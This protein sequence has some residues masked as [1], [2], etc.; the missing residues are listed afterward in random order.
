MS[1]IESIKK[2]CY[3]IILA[4][5]FFKKKI[6]TCILICFNSN[7]FEFDERGIYQNKG[8]IR[9]TRD[10]SWRRRKNGLELY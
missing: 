8:K 6:S 9:K 3:F 5:V 2:T 4:C 1:I 7:I 10:G